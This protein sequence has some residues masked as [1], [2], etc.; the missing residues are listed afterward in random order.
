MN[1]MSLSIQ[2]QKLL[3]VSLENIKGHMI[4]MAKDATELKSAARINDPEQIDHSYNKLQG[5]LQ[6]AKNALER[7][8]QKL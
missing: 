8:Y 5:H 2:Q 3:E 6:D 7:F 1:L 4:L